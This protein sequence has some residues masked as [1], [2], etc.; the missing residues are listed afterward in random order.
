MKRGDIF[1]VSLDPTQG[2]EQQGSRPVVVVSSTEF[3][4]A[5]RVP[6]VC[7]ITTGGAFAERIGFIVPLANTR[8]IGAV[9]CDQPRAMDLKARKARKVETLPDDILQDVL[10]RLATIFE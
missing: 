10:A 2:H 1:L 7:P 8:T 3:N 4:R 5:T 9:R 6:V